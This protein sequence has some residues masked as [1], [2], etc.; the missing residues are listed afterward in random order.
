M[1]VMMKGEDTL[2]CTNLCP[3]AATRPWCHVSVA[4]GISQL[5]KCSQCRYML[6]R[7]Q[8]HPPDSL[9]FTGHGREQ[10]PCPPCISYG[11]TRTCKTLGICNQG[12]H[13]IPKICLDAHVCGWLLEKGLWMRRW[14]HTDIYVGVRAYI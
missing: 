14:V 6:E 11:E 12:A 7:P 1:V 5:P 13:I 10:R 8:A 2:H 3:L 4:G 9:S